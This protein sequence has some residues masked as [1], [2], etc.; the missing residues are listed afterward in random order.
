VTIQLAFIASPLSMQQLYGVK[1]TPGWL[2]IRI[3]Y[4]CGASCLHADCC[5]NQLALLISN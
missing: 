1:A 5:F 3:M 2:G 4:L